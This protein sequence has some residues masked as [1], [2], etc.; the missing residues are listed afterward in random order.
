MVDLGD[1][2]LRVLG[3]LPR[4][5]AAVDGS[6]RA[7]TV[8]PLPDSH[9]QYAPP[10]RAFCSASA[11]SGRST[12]RRSWWSRSWTQ[13]RDDPPCAFAS[14]A[15]Q[16]D[17]PYVEDDVTAAVLPRQHLTRRAGPRA[18]RRDPKHHGELATERERF[19]HAVDRHRDASVDR[20][21]DVVSMTFELRGGANTSSRASS[22][23]APCWTA[24][25]KAPPPVRLRRTRGRGRAESWMQA[26][27]S[28]SHPPRET[29]VRRDGLQRR[30]RDASWS[31]R[32][33]CL[34]R[35]A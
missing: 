2:Y 12:S 35:S 4:K 13:S 21:S 7:A 15:Q 27:R 33:R 9:A 5:V 1:R 22:I 16:P 8:G 32:H 29:S 25:A 3:Q 18:V 10:S 11:D 20:R 17:A 14:A 19:D 30:G 26:R 28:R 23:E 31:R 6:H 34:H 24:A